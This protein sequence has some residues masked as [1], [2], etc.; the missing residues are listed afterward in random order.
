MPGPAAGDDLEWRRGARLR[1]MSDMAGSNDCSFRINRAR[2]DELVAVHLRSPGY[3]VAAFKAGEDHLHP[4]EAAEIGPIAGKRLVHLQCHFGLDTLCLA[5]RGAVVTG[6]DFSLTAIAAARALSAETGIPARFVAGN[7]Y[8]APALIGERFDVV[9]VSWGA[10]NWLPNLAAW[11]KVVAEMLE[12]GGF[13]YLL[14]G[15]PLA[16]A[17]EQQGPASPILPVCDYFQKPGPLVNFAATSYTG[18]PDRLANPEM[19][20]W[21]HP[22]GDV[23]TALVEAGL[24]LDWLHEFDRVAWRMFPC[25]EEGADHM[26]RMP[27]GRPS[28]PLAYSIRA[29]KPA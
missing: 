9:Y 1:A 25:L 29:R 2:W 6:L 27:A 19:H 26:W 13:L 20:E 10:I 14:E 4:I 22:L 12:F 15:H 24:T 3:R 21:I 23:V 17:L 8:D 11:A 28:L 16:M 7:V 18:D 5:R